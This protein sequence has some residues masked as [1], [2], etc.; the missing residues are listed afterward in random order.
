M[1]LQYKYK[2]AGCNL[3]HYPDFSFDLKKNLVKTCPLFGS[4]LDRHLKR[5]KRLQL[6]SAFWFGLIFNNVF[7]KFI[8]L[9]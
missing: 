4:T 3:K 9:I 6:D 1:E 5:S 8:D 2:I 7:S